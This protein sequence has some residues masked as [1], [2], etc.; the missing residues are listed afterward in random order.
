MRLPGCL[1]ISFSRFSHHALEGD[2]QI[3]TLAWKMCSSKV[4]RP[5]AQKS[6]R[7]TLPSTFAELLNRHRL[8][9]GVTQEELAE[10]AGLSVRGIVY[11][12]KGA[13]HPYSD[14]VQRLAAAL[15]LPV[16]E[17]RELIAAARLRGE[18]G[19]EDGATT[20]AHDWAGNQYTTEPGRA[21]LLPLP[22]PA[23]PLLGRETDVEAV[24]ALLRREEVWLLTLTGPGGVGKTRLA[25]QVATRMR[26]HFADGVVFVS[27]A[28]IAE[29][30][31]VLTTIAQTLGV[32]DHEGRPARAALATLLRHRHLLLVLDN[33]EHVSA[34]AGEVAGVRAVCAG[35]RLL[36]T[37]RASLRVQVERLYNVPRLAL[38]DPHALPAVEEI[39]RIAAVPLR[40]AGAGDQRATSR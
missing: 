40:A 18:A 16:S 23:T 10:R 19:A 32:S 3:V 8:A 36:V 33:F 21:A 7:G 9:T 39:G 35:V 5:M 26:E 15:G 31:Q 13:R 2:A 24:T 17:E 11:L 22:M 6:P 29:A 30:N 25:L 38:P 1:G 34:A 27:L 28:P 37:S 14:T 12:E 4:D 20:S